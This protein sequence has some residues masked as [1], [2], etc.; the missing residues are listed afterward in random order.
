[1]VEAGSGSR[2]KSVFFFFSFTKSSASASYIQAHPAW[3]CVAPLMEILCLILA[4]VAVPGSVNLQR[5]GERVNKPVPREPDQGRGL[6][7]AESGCRWGLV[8]VFTLLL[9]LNVSSWLRGW[10]GLSEVGIPS[11]DS[12]CHD[13]YSGRD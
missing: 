3:A 10:V 12:R 4:S 2:A 8:S 1:M 7:K 11:G 13:C 5:M 6:P 9:P